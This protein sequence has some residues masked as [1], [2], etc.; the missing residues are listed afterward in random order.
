M[1]QISV[2]QVFFFLSF[3]I[4]VNKGFEL[5]L[6]IKHWNICIVQ[7]GLVNKK[8]SSDIC[9]NGQQYFGQV[10]KAAKT[11][12]TLFVWGLEQVWAWMHVHLSEQI[13]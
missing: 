8:K 9:N 13:L 7:L 2:T 5:G 3:R 4:K 10:S 12:L 6:S 1:K 11:L